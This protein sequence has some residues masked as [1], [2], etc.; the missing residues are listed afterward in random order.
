MF[1]LIPD[2]VATCPYCG[3]TLVAEVIE[4]EVESL[5]PTENGVYVDCEVQD[6]APADVPRHYVMP[7]VYHLPMQMRVAAWLRR[8]YRVWDNDL[9]LV[10][11]SLPVDVQMRLAGAPMLPGLE[12]A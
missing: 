7:Y 2:S 9:V 3:A 12:A 11:P 1:V 4:W 6:T 5:Q 10:A 8:W